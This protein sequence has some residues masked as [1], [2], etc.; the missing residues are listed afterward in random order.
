MTR[1][2]WHSIWQPRYQALN[3]LAT[4]PLGQKIPTFNITPNID[5]QIAKPDQFVLFYLNASNNL[6]ALG[7]CCKA[8]A[9][10]AANEIIVTRCKIEPD[11][12]KRHKYA[13]SETDAQQT[14]RVK[15]IVSIFQNAQQVCVHWGK[16]MQLQTELK[17]NKANENEENC[18][19]SVLNNENLMLWL[20]E[21]SIMDVIL[22]THYM[23]IVDS[24]NEP[25]FPKHC[26]CSISENAS[27]CEFEPA[28]KFVALE[29]VALD[30]NCVYEIMSERYTCKT[31]L[32]KVSLNCL[33]VF[34]HY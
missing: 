13:I 8:K 10:Q 20:Q 18:F 32:G 5:K 25:Q 30:T 22:P 24:D 27:P 31:H 34:I 33:S 1:S 2:F 6:L 23:R 14:V 9:S 28:T 11:C 7:K 29:N 19:E 21:T 3:I 16:Q 17:T 4:I 12:T 15:N 26:S